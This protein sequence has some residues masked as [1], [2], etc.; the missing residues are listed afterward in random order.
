MAANL[1]V[2]DGQDGEK[3]RT[4]SFSYSDCFFLPDSHSSN[5]LL[6]N[7]IFPSN[8]LFSLSDLLSYLPTIPC[9]FLIT[10][11][12]IAPAP[13][14]LRPLQGRIILVTDACYTFA[15]GAFDAEIV[16][17]VNVASLKDEFA[18]IWT[19]EE[20]IAALKRSSE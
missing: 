16:H 5:H 13:N 3:V 15:K 10:L 14:V 18:E 9:S 20:V 19:T 8:L 7:M 4:R 12:Q 2:C 17:A 1:G 11:D 6:S